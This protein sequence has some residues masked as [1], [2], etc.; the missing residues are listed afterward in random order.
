MAGG[1]HQTV[2]AYTVAT[3]GFMECFATRNAG[4]SIGCA[5]R[6]LGQ[7]IL[8]LEWLR[9]QVRFDAFDVRSSRALPGE[10]V[11]VASAGGA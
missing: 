9:P 11:A 6:E 10:Q 1:F 5:P 2:R 7:A 3:T 8:P 4:G